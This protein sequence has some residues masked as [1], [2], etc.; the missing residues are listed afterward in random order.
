MPR[1][2]A[3]RRAGVALVAIW[4]L[5][6]LACAPPIADPIDNTS[7]KLESYGPP[8][9]LSQVI[10]GTTVSLQ[11]VQEG[12][13]V[14]GSTGCNAF[15]GTYEVDGSSLTINYEIGPGQRCD[16]SAIIE[17]EQMFLATFVDAESY[18][19]DGDML[20]IDCGDRVLVFA[21]R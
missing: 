20:T 12:H 5:A 19:I 17:Q 7:W 2:R 15:H 6:L 4:L 18:L 14:T 9:G 10:E 13:V 16:L 11:F 3:F 1:H 21:R 8:D